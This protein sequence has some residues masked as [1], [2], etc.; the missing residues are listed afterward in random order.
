MLNSDCGA[1]NGSGDAA[2]VNDA[3]VSGNFS[4]VLYLYAVIFLLFVPLPS[5]K[6]SAILFC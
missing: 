1:Y 6:K 4:V 3:A 5:G 2:A